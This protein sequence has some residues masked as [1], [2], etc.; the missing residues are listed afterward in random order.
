MREERI[1]NIPELAEGNWAVIKKFS[2][3]ESARI[4]GASFDV[5]IDAMSGAKKAEGNLNTYELIMTML[6]Y[7]I[8][9]ASFLKPGMT[10]EER[11]AYYE[12]ELDGE[13]GDFL[14]Q[15]INSF[16]GPTEAFQKK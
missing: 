13:A 5:K 12:N 4:K 6:T 7:G 9:E 10:T 8:K 15:K 2:I 16:N 11:R 3:G 14:F 1:E